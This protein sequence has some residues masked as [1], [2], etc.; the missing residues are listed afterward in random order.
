MAFNPLFVARI[1]AI[2]H[3]RDLHNRIDDLLGDA[4]NHFVVGDLQGAIAILNNALMSIHANFDVDT[5]HPHLSLQPPLKEGA[6]ARTIDLK[7]TM[8]NLRWSRATAELRFARQDAAD[9]YDD[10]FPEA[11]TEEDSE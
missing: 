5:D 3:T 11:M 6:D 8:W 10:A 9:F 2:D 4:N 7:R 1:H